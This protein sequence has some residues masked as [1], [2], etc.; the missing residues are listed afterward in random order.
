MF[1][2]VG[3]ADFALERLFLSMDFRI[4]GGFE[5]DSPPSLVE[6]ESVGGEGWNG[7]TG[8]GTLGC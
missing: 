4:G 5:R 1:R 2:S 6:V 8:G 7:A 3:G